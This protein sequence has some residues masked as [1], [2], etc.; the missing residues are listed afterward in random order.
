MKK[1]SLILNLLLIIF[2]MGCAD[3]TPKVR[4]S[5]PENL[6]FSEVTL[7]FDPVEHATS[8]L[9]IGEGINDTTTTNN[10]TFKEEGVFKVRVV[11]KAKGYLDSLHS[12]E[13]EVLVSFADAKPFMT[14]STDITTNFKDDTVVTFESLD[15]TF[16]GVY[17]N[18]ITSSNY[19]YKNDTLTIKASYLKTAF[20]NNPEQPSLIFT[21]TFE[22]GNQTHL[23]F[24]TIKK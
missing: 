7:A 4:L 21:Y 15:Y 14:S 23:G 11:A 10:Y 19:T 12:N 9:I 13:I 2:L 16:K 3:N 5:T 18:S 6:R 20:E 1:V 8:Y 17:G 22:R 24:I